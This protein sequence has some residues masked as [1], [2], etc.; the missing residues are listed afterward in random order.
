M[1]VTR[2]PLVACTGIV[3]VDEIF[4]MESLP[5]HEG[6]YSAIRHLEIGG[7]VAANAAVAVARLGGRAAFNG[8]IG[9]DALGDRL[10]DEFAAEGVDTAGC[11]RIPGHPTPIS[12]V[13]V[14]DDG[15][16]TVVNHVAPG[17]FAEADPAAAAAIGHPDAVLVDCRWI[18]GACATLDAA[19]VAGVPGIVDVDRELS[20]VTA[21]EIYDRATHLVFSRAGLIGT[22]DI[23]DLDDALRT[24]ADRTSAWVAVTDGAEGA[25]WVTSGRRHH[26]PAIHV[27]V[28]D[29][30]GAG[31]VFHGAFALALAEGRPEPEAVRFANVA[32]GL[33]CARV[34]GRAGIPDRGAV[35]AVLNRV[36]VA[37]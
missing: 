4:S 25:S 31:D 29:T 13:L 35:E 28:V 23:D 15:R 20:D 17:L 36:G 16:R 2:S 12:A 9:D 14:A 24:V 10:L 19:R 27:P 33:K 22:T 34:G 3:T 8:C 37:S 11:Q 6:K 21:R 26:Q 30:A 7:G 32:A 1:E 18:A 5:E